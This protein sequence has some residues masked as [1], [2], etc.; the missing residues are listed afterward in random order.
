MN[1]HTILVPGLSIAAAL[2]GLL[3]LGA[4]PFRGDEADA[5]IW[6]NWVPFAKIPAT[7]VSFNH[8]PAWTWIL[9]WWERIPHSD[10]ELWIRLPSLFS[11]MLVPPAAY[12]LG[13]VAASPRVGLI[14]A[15]LAATSPFLF[16]FA[17]DTR[18]YPLLTALACLGLAC[19]VQAIKQRDAGGGRSQYQYWLGYIVI[20]SIL[21]IITFSG[22]YFPLVAGAIVLTA[23][24]LTPGNRM[25]LALGII[26]ANAI[27]FGLWIAQP[28][29]LALILRAPALFRSVDALDVLLHII[30]LHGGEHLPLVMLPSLFAGGVALWHWRRTGN[31]GWIG[32]GLLGAFL[33][34]VLMALAGLFFAGSVFHIRTVMWAMVPFYLM[35]AVGIAAM[36][37]KR[38]GYGVFTLIIL[39]NV[40]GMAME[41]RN[42]QDPWDEIL[43]AMDVQPGDAFVSCPGSPYRPF[44]VYYEAQTGREI[45]GVR[46]YLRNP[47]NWHRLWH[48]SDAPWESNR[49][50]T[51]TIN[52]RCNEQKLQRELAAEWPEVTYEW[53]RA[54][55]GPRDGSKWLRDRYDEWGVDD[56]LLRSGYLTITGRERG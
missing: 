43:A 36:P 32:L 6:A 44:A 45:E 41:L 3:W 5:W 26:V 16:T 42:Q 51:V 1:S 48:T 25:R 31:W 24:V 52:S 28:W 35:V 40:Y 15:A 33:A 50:W 2:A 17:R 20:A 29:G 55:Y 37:W 11:A 47:N 46:M 18:G 39:C 23:A 38:V 22:L 56:D 54:E 12:L 30:A 49:V 13:R 19:I 9:H 27:V 21:P 4:E 34:P 7:T 8:P 10:M 53:E 14:M